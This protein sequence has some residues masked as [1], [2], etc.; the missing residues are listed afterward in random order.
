MKRAVELAKRGV[1]A[2]NPNPLVGAVI[3][4]DG[5]IIG[6]GW[7]ERYGELHAERNALKSCSED[8]SGADMYVTL[9]PCCHYGKTPRCT[10]IIIEKKLKRVYIGSNDPNAKVNGGGIKRLKEAGIEV[11]DGIL[12]EECDKINKVFFHY[13]T[14]GTPYVVMKYAMTAD[15]RT[16]TRTGHSRWISGEESRL[17]VHRTRNALM[18]IMTGIGTVMRDDPMLNC[19]IDGGRNPV[20]IICDTNL[21]IL[22]TSN[23]IQTADKYPT[24][25]ATAC[26][27]IEKLAAVIKFGAQVVRVEKK[28]D[29]IDLC[30]LMKKLGAQGID[31]VLLEGGAQLN[32]SALEAGI[33]N[34]LQVYVAPKLFGGIL[35]KPPIGGLGV[36]TADK[37]YMLS[38]PEITVFGSDVLLEY[39]VINTEA[40]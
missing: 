8:P 37:A 40:M 35:A 34:R 12:K 38:K 6:E 17:N 24:L 3:V 36:E 23:I 30:D 7:H 18:G 9:E 28:G 16:A 10:D 20:R 26:D 39:D 14:S 11:F 31:S 5:R 2:V 27:D 19:R 15:G 13:I 1:G 25:I 21:S 22:L 4:K 33:V 32:A 29:H